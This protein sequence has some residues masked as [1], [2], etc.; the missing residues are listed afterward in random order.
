M[1]PTEDNS[2]NGIL[3][4]Y[5]DQIS[6]IEK[7]KKFMYELAEQDITVTN[8]FAI[9]RFMA[10]ECVKYHKNP[11]FEFAV[12]GAEAALKMF[13]NFTDRMSKN[14]QETLDRE[15]ASLREHE[16]KKIVEDTQEESDKKKVQKKER[17]RKEKKEKKENPKKHQ[18]SKKR[19]C[20][21]EKNEKEKK[22]KKP[23][24]V[25]SSDKLVK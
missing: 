24:I 20:L 21:K 17:K 2:D 1:N 13:A 18:D 12:S 4:N 3:M 25:E 7:F 11:V 6:D 14:A 10:D 8:F 22:K 15:K 5:L 16:E 19:K 9:V 23:K